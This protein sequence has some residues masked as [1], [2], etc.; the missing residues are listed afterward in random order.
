MGNVLSIPGGSMK[1]FF[2]GEGFASTI[3]SW[4][5]AERR[6]DYRDTVEITR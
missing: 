3:R 2:F 6:G 1:F 5:V 4:G